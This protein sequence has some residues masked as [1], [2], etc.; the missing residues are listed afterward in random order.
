IARWRDACENNERQLPCEFLFDVLDQPDLAQHFQLPASHSWLLAA[1]EMNIP[2]FTPG[3]ED[4]TTG[5]FFAAAVIKK[6][7]AHH[8]CVKTGTEQMQALVEWYEA[9]C[10]RG[11]SKPSV[12][13]FQVG[14]GI[15]GDFP[16]CAVPLM[17]QD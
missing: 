7:V 3:W 17:I 14:G 16:I 6:Q 13:F 15:A 9:N 10:R 8:Q 5:N 12:G 11:E 4:S 1:K 2:I